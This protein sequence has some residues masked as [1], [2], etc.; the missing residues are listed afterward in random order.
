[1]KKIL[2]TF[3]ILVAAMF[4]VNGCGTQN[5][6][7]N[8]NFNQN[9]FTSCNPSN[10]TVPFGQGGRYTIRV[11]GIENGTCHWQYALQLPQLNQ[12]KDCLYP[13]DK[14][15]EKAFQHLFGQ[16]KQAQN[17]QLMLARNKIN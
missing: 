17:V 7:S 9:T 6:G 4:L 15:S 5:Q 2:S 13:K 11:I 1:M 10:Q 12:T 14:M 16:D 8:Q 3:L